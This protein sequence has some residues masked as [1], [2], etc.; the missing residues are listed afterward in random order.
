MV[1]QR[2]A[3]LQGLLA[4]HGRLPLAGMRILDAGCGGGGVLA[5]LSE[6]GAESRN[7]Y[8]VELLPQRAAAAHACHPALQ[9]LQGNAAIQA[10]P[11]R[12]FDLVLFYT[13][14]SS[15]LDP[16]MQRQMADETMRVLKPGGAVVWYDLRVPN[17]NN[18]NTRPLG[19][20]DI[21]ALFPSLELDLRTTTLLPPLARRLGVLTGIMYPMLSALP[22]LRTHHIGLLIDHRSN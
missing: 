10:F 19:R 4:A 11:D 8:G 7:L 1:G 6:W 16:G 5:S 14:F 3:A 22:W 2:H 20:K 17:P 18:K 13:V 21:A 9:I 15:V 12:C